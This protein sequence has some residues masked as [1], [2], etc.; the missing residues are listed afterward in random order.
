MNYEGAGMEM[1]E[2]V[3]TLILGLAYIVGLLACWRRLGAQSS[4]DAK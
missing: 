2:M 3:M 1:K 4:R